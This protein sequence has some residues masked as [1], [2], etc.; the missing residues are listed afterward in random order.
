MNSALRACIATV[1][2]LAAIEVGVRV[3]GISDVPLYIADQ[4]IGYLPRPSQTGS[5]L[6]RNDWQF[7]SL[8]MGADEFIPSGAVD[9]LLLGDSIVFGG[10]P[11]RGE[12]RL[13]PQLSRLLGQPVWP[14]SA[15]SWSLR[16]ELAYL[17]RY[18]QVADASDQIIFVLNS[19]DFSQAS[20]WACER[21][22]PRSR[23]MFRALFVLRKYVYDWDDCTHSPQALIVP[24]GSW[25][26]ELE[27]VVV[28]A[29]S[30][31]SP[32]LFFLY[33]ERSELADKDELAKL[34]SRAGE[35]Q[36][37]GFDTTPVFSVGRDPRWVAELYRDGI[38]PTA[39]GYRVLAQ[40]IASPSPKARLVGASR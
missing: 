24:D 21:I 1:C 33:P 27:R 10:N 40:I 26:E 16:N 28:D 23:P 12:E 37:L 19:G 35:I 11:Y 7:N 5:F 13:G 36:R 8:S 18:P 39:E 25:K 6:R 32:V 31:G 29:H 2:V 3:C 38:H 9:T 17:R 15:P 22:H 20:S 30:R 4:E 34:E 14:V